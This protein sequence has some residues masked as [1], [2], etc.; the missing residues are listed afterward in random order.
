MMSTTTTTPTT[1]KRT[2]AQ[3]LKAEH[4]KAER[5]QL[6]RAYFLHVVL[7]LVAQGYPRP[8]AQAQLLIPYRDFAWDFAYI[9]ARLAVELHGGLHG[10]RNPTTGEWEAGK[11]SGHTSATGIERDAEK[12]DEL[13]AIGWRQLVFTPS[14]VA[15]GYAY[16]MTERAL[17]MAGLRNAR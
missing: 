15:S 6:E 12:L 3:L 16:T 9:P 14:Q 4:L 5:E 11:R 13:T 8:K 1:R 17:K 7:P 10:R 2:P